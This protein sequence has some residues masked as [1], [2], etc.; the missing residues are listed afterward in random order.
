MVRHILKKDWMLL[1]P[2]VTALTVLQGLLAFARFSEGQF[3]NLPLVPGSL[4]ELLAVATVI[5]LVV[6]QDPI[7][8]VRQ[9]WLVRPIARRNLFLAKL[10]FVVVLVQGPMFVTDLLQGLANGFSFGQSAAA[11]TACAVWVLL[12]LSLPVL[13]FAALTATMTETFVAALG[14]FAVVIAFMI[15]PGLVGA[16]RPAAL[17]GFAWVPFLVREAVLLVAAGGVLIL[18]YRWRRSWAARALF[19]AAL[20]AGLAEGSE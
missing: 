6:H 5:V 20:V 7:P 9:D 13:A 12:T 8:G 18:Q 4:L 3:V 15:V 19:A 14:V 10:L 2:L 17:T 11:A 16:N 1:W